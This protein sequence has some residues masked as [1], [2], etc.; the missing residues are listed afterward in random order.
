MVDLICALAQL[1]Q[2]RRTANSYLGNC[3]SLGDGAGHRV[4]DPPMRKLI[5]FAA[6]MLLG[7]IVI[8]SVVPPE[9]RPVTPAPHNFEHAG[10][11]VLTGL[12]FGL[13][14]QRWRLGQAAALVVFSGTI[15]LVQLLVAGRHSRL[16]DFLVDA[17]SVSL[18]V[19][20][21]AFIDL[22]I[23]SSGRAKP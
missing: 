19:G 17:V 10:I 2:T 4:I 20:L 1:P 7:A 15:E 12:A 8:L 5:R 23:K 21:A 9:D 22:Q 3:L 16:S 6:W 11:F 18:G 13:G 14:Y